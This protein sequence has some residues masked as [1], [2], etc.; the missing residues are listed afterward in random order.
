MLHQHAKCCALIQLGVDLPGV[1]ADCSGLWQFSSWLQQAYIH[2]KRTV[3]SKKPYQLWRILQWVYTCKD[4]VNL[5]MYPSS[6]SIPSLVQ[7]WSLIQRNLNSQPLGDGE[8][9]WSCLIIQ[10]LKSHC[11]NLQWLNKDYCTIGK[12][13]GQWPWYGCQMFHNDFDAWFFLVPS[14]YKVFRS[15]ETDTH[16]FMGKKLDTSPPYLTP[17]LVSEHRPV[18]RP[19]AFVG[20]L[21]ITGDLKVPYDT[22]M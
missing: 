8:S 2:F 5:Q 1:N 12:E 13:Q 20:I 3:P 18:S 19:I 21:Q 6:I 4:V 15:K 9:E 11:R 10:C 17:L 16:G 14:S 7:L 22:S